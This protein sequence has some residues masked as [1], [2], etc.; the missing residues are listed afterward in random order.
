MAD[1]E[2]TEIT[3]NMD[4]FECIATRRSIRKFMNLD[5]PME[6]VGA[7]IDAGR[8]A[9]SSGNVQ[10][11]RFIIVKN[12]DTIGKI[13]EAC[14]QQL[15][16][17]QAPVVIVV[18]SDSEKLQQFYGTRGERLYAIQ[19][20]GCCIQNM[21]LGAHAIGLGSCW[22]GAFDE[23]MLARAVN[24]PENIRP[25]AVLPLGYPDEIV[26]TPMHYTLEALCFLEGY[27][28]RIVN[29]KRVLQNPNV[30]GRLS[31]G[32]KETIDTAKDIA[33]RTAKQFKK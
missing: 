14:M 2:K 18:C 8:Y 15:W 22:V 3:S 30:F 7:V 21:L 25:Q 27:G 11:W 26:P 17:A 5:V 28:S 20:C 29:I 32:I 31:D 10:N 12:K 33:N 16:I 6:M 23:T 24:I 9:P 19:N 1:D 13:A 4:I